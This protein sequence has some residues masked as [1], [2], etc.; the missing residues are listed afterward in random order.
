M[1]SRTIVPG[2]EV[3][4]SRSGI[5][6]MALFDLL[7][8]RWTMRILW[9]LRGEALSFRGLQEK[10]GELSPT[11]LNS[12]I[13]QLSQAQLLVSTSSGYAL[14]ALGVSLMETL[15]PLRNW[16]TKWDKALEKAKNKM[17]QN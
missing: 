2:S 4:G 11:V 5:P 9:E 12:R 1:R 8:Q 3:R 14:T 7:G 6:I 17:E 10:C 16:A 13:K 15:D